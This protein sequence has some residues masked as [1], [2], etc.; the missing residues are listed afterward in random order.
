MSNTESLAENLSPASVDL[1]T[2][3]ETL[4]LLKTDDAVRCVLTL[5]RP[6]GTLTI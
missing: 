5:P 2:C 1:I 6:G 4:P 3:A